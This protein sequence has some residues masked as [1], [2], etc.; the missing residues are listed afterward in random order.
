MTV[1]LGP[2]SPHT[3]LGHPV[4]L[5]QEGAPP[6]TTVRAPDALTS[7]T[8]RM[9]WVRRASGGRP[10]DPAAPESSSLAGGA[11]VAIDSSR[12]AKP[13]RLEARVPA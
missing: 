5:R 11:W 6:A 2:Q 13:R 3:T 12:L 4:H 10:G 1:L 9:G 8:A 7:F